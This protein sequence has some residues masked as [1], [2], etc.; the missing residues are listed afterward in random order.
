MPMTWTTAT[1]RIGGLFSSTDDARLSPHKYG[2]VYGSLD[3]AGRPNNTG[4][5]DAWKLD[6]HSVNMC[7]ELT[8]DSPGPRAAVSRGERG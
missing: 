6:Y 7:L 8:A 4:K 5:G 1:P 3:D 2:G